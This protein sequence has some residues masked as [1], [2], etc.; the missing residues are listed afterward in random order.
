M[1][2]FKNSELAR[3]YNISEKT[4]RNWILGA[5]AGKNELEI[6]V[7]DRSRAYI[8]DTVRNELIIEKMTILGKKYRNSKTHK[9]L[10]VSDELYK[11][12]THGQIQDIVM[13]LDKSAEFPFQYS[14]M[15]PRGVEINDGYYRRLTQDNKP[16]S[17]AFTV[18]AINEN[19]SL[20]K[21]YMQTSQ[22]INIV[23]IGGRTGLIAKSLISIFLVDDYL[24]RYV[25]VD[26]SSDMVRCA[27]TTVRD[28]YGDGMHFQGY[29]RDIHKQQIDD[30]LFDARIDNNL[31]DN[32]V[33]FAGSTLFNLASPKQALNNISNS[34]ASRDLFILTMKL[35]SSLARRYFD[36]GPK[37]EN[38]LLS[39][40]E[41]YML[42]LLNIDEDCC[43]IEQIY[44]EELR[45]RKAQARLKYDI[46]LVFNIKGK[47][48]RIDFSK[49]E[50]IL[51]W[52]YWH[53]NL[54]EIEDM[55][56]EAGFTV[57]QATKSPDE[58]FGM[59]IARVKSQRPRLT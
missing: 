1:K 6:F 17:Q 3:Q 49:G 33:I 51:L 35:D 14:H 24:A 32:L 46:T 5:D 53:K 11:Y 23:E 43:E 52:R 30:I 7:D 25:D 40:G 29:V 8:A 16:N 48:K 20:I 45:I 39:P 2:Y 26:V 28:H 50:A 42:D 34:L 22:S 4:V 56:R 9:V 58:Q 44:D 57:M 12:Y 27:Q 41:K 10:H 38:K 15:G 54:E 55:M 13:H 47:E 21:S 37:F 31:A 36:F 18:Q 19:I 59:I